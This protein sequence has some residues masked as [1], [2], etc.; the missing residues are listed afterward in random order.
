MHIYMYVQ[1]HQHLPNNNKCHPAKST[2]PRHPFGAKLGRFETKRRRRRPT[3]TLFLVV[4]VVVLTP[5]ELYTASCPSP[6][7]Q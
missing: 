5:R 2:K 7:Q 6:F 4:V 1:Y 3:P